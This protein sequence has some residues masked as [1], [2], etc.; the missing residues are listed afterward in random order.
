MQRINLYIDKEDY[1]FLKKRSGTV[2][3][4]IRFAIE[5][6]IHEIQKKEVNVITSASEKEDD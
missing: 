6:Y 5:N 2:S 3:E 4:H 1:E